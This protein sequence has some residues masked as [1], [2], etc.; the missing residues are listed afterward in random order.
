MLYNPHNLTL[1]TH[2]S[3]QCMNGAQSYRKLHCAHAKSVT[4]A[5][6]PD[7]YSNFKLSKYWSGHGES[8]AYYAKEAIA[9]S[10]AKDTDL[11]RVILTA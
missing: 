5:I 9:K 8:D 6:T 7:H 10:V 3:L 2:T 11:S 4:K 1:S